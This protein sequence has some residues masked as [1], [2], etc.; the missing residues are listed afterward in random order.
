MTVV[1]DFPT[2]RQAA[3]IRSLVS[4]LESPERAQAL[5]REPWLSDDHIALVA[6]VSG[7]ILGFGRASRV[8]LE[9]ANTLGLPEGTFVLR[10]LVVAPEQ[11]RRGIG[12]GVVSA[13]AEELRHHPG[14]THLVL[15]RADE[16]D[17]GR[18]SAD[19]LTLATAERRTLS[20]TPRDFLY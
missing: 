9:Q 2:P 18:V 13:M 14:A 19:L 4:R 16:S 1:A 6:T 7:V 10:G 11:R 15:P 12:R 17:N 20:A 5:L 3:A 8:D